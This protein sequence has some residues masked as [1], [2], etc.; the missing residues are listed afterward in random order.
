MITK[1]KTFWKDF[2]YFQQLAE[3]YARLYLDIQERT[4]GYYIEEV[5]FGETTIGV[6]WQWF[7]S[8]G[9]QDT[10]WFYIPLDILFDKMAWEGYIRKEIAAKKQKAQEENLQRAQAQKAKEIAAAKKLLA[11]AGEL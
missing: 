10:D 5:E 7:G 8:Y 4:D 11:D 1:Y 2:T 9:A 6:R 3:K